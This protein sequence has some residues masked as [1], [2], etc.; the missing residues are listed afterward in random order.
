MK[1]LP[2]DAVGP[3]ADPSWPQI[4]AELRERPQW[5]VASADKAPLGMVNGKLANV[6]VSRPSEWMTF[7]QACSAA[8]VHS[9]GVGYVLT[10]SD[11]FS[12][13]DLDVKDA[14][15]PEHLLRFE[16]IITTMDSYTERSRSGRGW[17]VWVRGK[18]GKGRRRDRVEVYSQERFIICTGD[19]LRAQPVAECQPLLDSMVSR[20]EPP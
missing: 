3:Q 14:T 9:L 4:P 2:N 1:V 17:H 20:M 6:S 19:V 13:I 8:A 5:A 7:D 18:I 10:E 12:C 15:P 11:P 16:Q